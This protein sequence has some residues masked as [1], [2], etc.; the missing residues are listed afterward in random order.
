MK[1]ILSAVVILLT[2]G[3]F[4]ATA[5]P[6]G[7]SVSSPVTFEL[8]AGGGVTLPTGT[9]NNTNNTGW[10]VGGL[11]RIGGWLPLSIVATGA[12]H[13]L[14]N[15]GGSDATT[16]T[17]LTGGFEYPLSALAVRPYLSAEGMLN[18]I[19]STA[20]NSPTNNRQGI[21]LGIGV[22]FG[23]P[24]VGNFDTSL[25]YQMLNLWGKSSNENDTVAQLVANVTFL[26]NVL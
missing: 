23:A 16:I 17:A 3:S 12:Y 24:G 9:L 20:A 2:A 19:S 15:A 25:K 5:Q 6:V 18:Y 10:H 21:S 1:H 8:G 14:P 13:K 11:A 26:F 22:D 7:V 4:I